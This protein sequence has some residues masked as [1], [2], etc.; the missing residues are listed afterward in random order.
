MKPTINQRWTPLEEA[1]PGPNALKTLEPGDKF[2]QNKTHTVLVYPNSNYPPGETVEPMAGW[3]VLSIRR[4][5]RAAE[6]DWRILMRIKNEICGEDREAVQLFPGL[7]RVVDTANQY[8]LFVAPKGF[9]IGLGQIEQEVSGKERADTI[10]A[11]QREFA[12]DDPLLRL[13]NNAPRNERTPIF[14]MPVYPASLLDDEGVGIPGGRWRI[15]WI[16][17]SKESDDGNAQPSPG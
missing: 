7:R 13:V 8:F 12:S 17:N 15:E 5:D 1:V 6:C 11:V 10:G 16:P 3:V 4:N 9:I 2:F 14:P